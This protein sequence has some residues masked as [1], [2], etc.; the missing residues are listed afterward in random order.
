MRWRGGRG[1]C[2]LVMRWRGGFMR[3]RRGRR[4]ERKRAEWLSNDL[5]ISYRSSYEPFKG[6]RIIDH[7]R[8]MGIS[9]AFQGY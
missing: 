6:S 3:S 4:E 8:K 5:A 7:G 1:D 9:Q 2:I